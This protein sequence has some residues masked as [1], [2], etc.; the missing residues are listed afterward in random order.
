MVH[1]LT[2][3]ME[4]IP[5]RLEHVL[6]RLH[7]S[8]QQWKKYVMFMSILIIVHVHMYIGYNNHSGCTHSLPD[9][10]RLVEQRC[11]NMPL[12]T[13]SVVG[14]K[15]VCSVS[16]RWPTTHMLGPTFGPTSAYP[17]TQRWNQGLAQRQ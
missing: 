15:S 6:H 16:Q 1:V 10:T 11:S 13:N 14:P 12:V 9:S 7:G 3:D 17:F 5:P 2:E 8:Q 4:S